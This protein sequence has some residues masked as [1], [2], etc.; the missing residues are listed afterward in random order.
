MNPTSTPPSVPAF[1]IEVR[2]KGTNQVP[3]TIRDVS[4][5]DEKQTGQ[6][7]DSL[8]AKHP[9]FEFRYVPNQM[10]SEADAVDEKAEISYLRELRKR[11]IAECGTDDPAY[12]AGK[13]ERN[14][15]LEKQIGASR[16]DL[17]TLQA[18][19]ESNR[20][21][22]TA[23]PVLDF[24]AGEELEDSHSGIIVEV[25]EVTPTGFK[26]K[27]QDKS[28]PVSITKEGFCPNESAIF[29]VK[30]KKHRGKPKS[31]V[32][33]PEEKPAPA[34]EVPEKPKAEDPTPAAATAPAAAAEHPA[35][36]A[37]TPKHPQGK[38]RPGHPPARPHPAASRP[39]RPGSRPHPAKHQPARHHSGKPHKAKH[40]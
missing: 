38:V 19:V 25:L 39:A 21:P 27:Y 28:G 20:V 40:S 17:T 33:E 8:H 37:D 18:Q 30:P 26:Y 12:L 29:F 7:L 22:E 1:L 11:L 15:E 35:A 5:S 10:A 16:K 13:I 24:T 4:W 34:S 9:E 32:A 6:K 23:K 36:H 14:R 31:E 2:V 3:W